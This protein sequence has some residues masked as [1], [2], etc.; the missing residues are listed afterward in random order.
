MSCYTACHKRTGRRSVLATIE[1]GREPANAA[2]PTVQTARLRT[3]ALLGTLP[4]APG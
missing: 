4:L 3:R 1:L 2:K